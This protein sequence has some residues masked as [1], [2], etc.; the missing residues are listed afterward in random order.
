MKVEPKDPGQVGKIEGMTWRV[1][2]VLKV[3]GGGGVKRSEKSDCLP[4]RRPVRI[5]QVRQMSRQALLG[6]PMDG[7]KEAKYQR[8]R[9]CAVIYAAQSAG[10]EASSEEVAQQAP[11]A[12]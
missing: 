8:T 4:L 12:R 5:A 10:R 7:K 9:K 6:A 1:K 11:N 3:E 2:R